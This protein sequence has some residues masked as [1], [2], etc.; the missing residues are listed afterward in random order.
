M[1]P[2]SSGEVLAGAGGETAPVPEI[3]VS[4]AGMSVLFSASLP[5]GLFGEKKAGKERGLY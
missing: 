2:S 5:D 4:D 3:I 1:G